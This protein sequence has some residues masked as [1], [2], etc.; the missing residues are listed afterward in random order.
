LHD[1]YRGNIKE[2]N[3]NA[4][5]TTDS[6]GRIDFGGSFDVTQAFWFSGNMTGDDENEFVLQTKIYVEIISERNE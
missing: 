5:G 1:A 3:I 4:Y 2:L 6:I